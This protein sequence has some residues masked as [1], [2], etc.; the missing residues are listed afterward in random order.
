MINP[1]DKIAAIA[2]VATTEYRAPSTSGGSLIDQVIGK[3]AR[4]GTPEDPYMGVWLD[5]V[6]TGELVSRGHIT[7]KMF[8][9]EE[10]FIPK[11]PE[12]VPRSNLATRWSYISAE[13][14]GTARA[15]TW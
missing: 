4:V 9:K 8:P 10:L 7:P 1:V 12:F 3:M 15:C 5:P 14:I 11:G 13:G 6:G 2:L